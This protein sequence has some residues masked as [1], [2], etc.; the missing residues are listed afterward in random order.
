MEEKEWTIRGS[1]P[2]VAQE[3]RVE[4]QQVSTVISL[5]HFTHLSSNPALRLGHTNTHAYA[6]ERTSDPLCVLGLYP[7]SLI[8]CVLSTLLPTYSLHSLSVT[9]THPSS[10]EPDLSSGS[11][12][13]R[14]QPS[15]SFQNFS[16]SSWPAGK[17]VAKRAS[18]SNK[19]R[20]DTR[21]CRNLLER[22]KGLS[23]CAARADGPQPHG[24][25]RLL[26]LGSKPPAR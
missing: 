3:R 14:T 10:L 17:E 1:G 11:D 26:G 21:V 24:G 8:P 23:R 6:Q 25:L 22:W 15:K 20:V 19:R 7:F 13:A 12:L 16:Q 4:R 9:L 2:P 18:F 5:T